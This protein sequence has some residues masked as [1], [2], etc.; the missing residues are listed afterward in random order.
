[1]TRT[2]I[3]FISFLLSNS[4]YSQELKTS[5]ELQGN[6]KNEEF[7][8][9]VKENSVVIKNKKNAKAKDIVLSFLEIPK[10]NKSDEFESWSCTGIFNASVV[11]QDSNEVKEDLNE[12]IYFRLK[13][14][15]EK[16]LFEFSNSLYS[17]NFNPAHRLVPENIKKIYEE[18]GSLKNRM[19]LEK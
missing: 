19:K 13:L 4:I 2:I 14:K 17:N 12:Y 15:K 5:K 7:E 6:W 10:T 11:K 18:H 9:E 1:M 8:I 3:L 16:L